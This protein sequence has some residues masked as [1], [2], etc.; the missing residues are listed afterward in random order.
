MI[1]EK[2]L[3]GGLF[4]FVINRPSSSKRKHAVQPG[5]WLLPVFFWPQST[6]GELS[7]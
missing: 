6:T 7:G 2:S 4:V 3:I 1:V 5:G